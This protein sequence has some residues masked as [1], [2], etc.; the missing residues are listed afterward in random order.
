[1]QLIP[2]ALVPVVQQ[3]MA[4]QGYQGNLFAYDGNLNPSAIAELF[5]DEVTVRTNI[6]PDLIFPINSRG[7]PP[8]AAME[9]LLN[10]L[11][12][13]V[14]L[15]GP[16]GTATIAPYGQARGAGSWWPFALGAGVVVLGI[17]WAVFGGRR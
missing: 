12:P 8:N 14:T 17:G 2:P 10:T 5:F 11:Q 16:V 15:T 7:G 9:Q 13:S 4:S 6:T 1:M 3:F